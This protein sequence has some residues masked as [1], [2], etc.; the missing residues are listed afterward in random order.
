MH[1][2]DIPEFSDNLATDWQNKLFRLNICHIEQLGTLIAAPQGR[3]ALERLHVPLDRIQPAVERHLRER[4]KLSL[5]QPYKAGSDE[6]VSVLTRERFPMGFNAVRNPFA[7]VGFD[8]ALPDPPD[9]LERTQPPD[10]DLLSLPTQTTFED[11]YLPPVENQGRRGTCVAFTV[12]A[13]YQ[14]G[15]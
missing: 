14:R 12:L 3:I 1:L 13:Q 2:S 4:Y 8:A 10:D 9:P 5:S 6:H 7:E 11:E 15:P